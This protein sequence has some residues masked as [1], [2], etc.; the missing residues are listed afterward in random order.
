MNRNAIA[1]II[2]G[3]VLL[4]S[5]LLTFGYFGAK[6][7]HRDRLRREAMAAYE[8]KDYPQAERLLLQ[9]V[10]K[11]PDAEEEYVALANVYHEFGNVEMEAQM[12]QAASS[13]SPLNS[14][15]NTNMLICAVKAA[16]YSLLHGMLGRK[17]GGDNTFTDQELYLYVISSYRSGYPKDGAA[18]YK[19]YVSSDPEI[20][21]KNDLGRM[22]EFFATYETL[23]DGKRDI[24][25]RKSVV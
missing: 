25:D 14:E 7:M 24:L 8:K 2:S 19:K 1:V 4:A 11:D 21:H 3:V 20:F 16:N 15:Y 6:M 9:Y 12:W 22:A 17:T 10:Q 13:L 18:A 23:S 5:V